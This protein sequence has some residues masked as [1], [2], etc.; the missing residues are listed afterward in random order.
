VEV[1]MDAKGQELRVVREHLDGWRRRHGGRGRRIPE[2]LWT[3][4]ASVARVSGLRET[5]RA[6]RLRVEPL[7]ARI[8]GVKRPAAR[9]RRAARSTFVE[10]TGLGPF[11]GEEKVVELSRGGGHVMRIR[12]SGPAGTADLLRLAESFWGGRS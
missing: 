7:R 9:K 1:T 3:E 8:D 11:A 4:A 12:L 6:L 2:G 10:L 5:A